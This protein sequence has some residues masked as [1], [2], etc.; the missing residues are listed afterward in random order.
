MSA[1]AQ[2][3]VFPTA[4]HESVSPAALGFFLWAKKDG[5]LR[6]CIDYRA[7]NDITIKYSFPLPLVPTT[8]EQLRGALIF[9]KLNLRSPYNLIRIREGDEWKTAFITT[10]GH[11]EYLVMPYGL[12]NAPSVFQGCMNEVFRE[13]L[14]RFVIVLYRQHLDILPE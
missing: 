14:H 13:Y 12:A 8:L 6:P 2:K 3:N 9:S 4:Y 11:Y 7:L 1:W 5:G 10:M